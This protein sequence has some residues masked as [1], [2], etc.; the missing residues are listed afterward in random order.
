VTVR[1]GLEQAQYLGN[2]ACVADAGVLE[3]REA[4]AD[5]QPGGF[6]E[7]LLDPFP[8]DRVDTSLPG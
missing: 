7:K 1:V 8:P 6:V 5:G 2:E 3:E 4:L